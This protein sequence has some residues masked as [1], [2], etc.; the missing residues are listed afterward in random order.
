MQSHFV[1]LEPPYQIIH[2][3]GVVGIQIGTLIVVGENSYEPK[4]IDIYT[5]SHPVVSYVDKNLFKRKVGNSRSYQGDTLF[6]GGGEGN[7]WSKVE[8]NDVDVLGL[9]DAD[10]QQ[11]SYPFG[12]DDFVELVSS[13]FS[14]T[15]AIQNK[16]RKNGVYDLK[17]YLERVGIELELPVPDEHL[18]MTFQ[19]MAFKVEF[20]R[21]VPC[22]LCRTMDGLIE[23][24]L[25]FYKKEPEHLVPM[26]AHFLQQFLTVMRAPK[27][28][29]EFF[30]HDRVFGEHA[31]DDE[32]PHHEDIDKLVKELNDTYYE[33][34]CRT[35]SPF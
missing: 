16:P 27:A 32:Y 9:W 29:I 5:R 23:F 18:E 25:P 20:G 31:D 21:S 34:Y 30:N 22:L 2:Y 24:F 10:Q 13:G 11:D 15:D 7:V 1:K 33:K 26:V 28:T 35:P 17:N 3:G 8:V 19:E 12:W 14:R 4:S 6:W